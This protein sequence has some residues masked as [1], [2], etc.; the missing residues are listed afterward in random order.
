[1]RALLCKTHG[2]PEGLVLEDLDPPEIEH[3]KVRI[4]VHACGVNFPASC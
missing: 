1:M 3:G 2:P 4:R